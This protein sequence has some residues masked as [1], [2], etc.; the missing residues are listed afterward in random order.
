M[1][2]IE[3]LLVYEY[4][5]CYY[6]DEEMVMFRSASAAAATSPRLERFRSPGPATAV[7]RPAGM[8]V[9]QGRP[10]IQVQVAGHCISPLVTQ[11]QGMYD[12]ILCVF[13]LEGPGQLSNSVLC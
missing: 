7:V 10:K 13:L 8:H 3:S 5:Y 9:I 12:D 6:S 2:Q 1:S 4:S 11:A